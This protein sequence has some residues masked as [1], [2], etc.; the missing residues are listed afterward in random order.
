M[1]NKPPPLPSVPEP[2]PP[3]FRALLPALLSARGRSDAGRVE[4]LRT[5]KAQLSQSG[6]FVGHRRYAHGDDLRRLDWAAYARTGELFTK[7]LQ[8]EDRRA[9]TIVLDLSASMCCGTPPRRLGALRVAAIVAGLA[10]ARL[11][12]VAIA[13]AGAPNALARFAGLV[14]LPALLDHLRSLP[15]AASAPA[16]TAALLLHGE[17]IGSVHWIADFAPP[18]A[19]ELPLTALRRRGARLTGW[20]PTVPE[21]EAP[22]AGGYLRVVD[23]E[24]GDELAV[25]IDAAFAAELRRQLAA[26]DRQQR[27]MFAA[28]GAR[29]WRWPVPA[30][31]PALRDYL[32][33]VAACGR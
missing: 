7:Q 28:A 8:E 15:V 10:L 24:R 13:A 18:Q 31:A 14:Q 12:G 32:P 29:L 4:R 1:G 3:A 21:D 22:A 25:P 11:D 6:T 27:R 20:L 19:F 5:R 30:G 26:L 16:E 23:P 2:F 17:G 9:V 33:I